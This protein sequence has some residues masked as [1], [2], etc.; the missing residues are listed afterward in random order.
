MELGAI[1]AKLALMSM[2]IK[3]AARTSFASQSPAT[4]TRIVG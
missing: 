1:A 4:I 2:K 3:G